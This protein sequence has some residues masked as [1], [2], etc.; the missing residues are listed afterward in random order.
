M[1]KLHAVIFSF[2]IFSAVFSNAYALRLKVAALSPE[3]ST[4][5]N[6][7]KQGAKEISQ[8]TNGRVKF[9]FYPG[10]VMGSDKTVLRK[11]QVG[12]LH[13]A[14]FSNGMLNNLYNGS[15]VYNL[16]LKFNSY[17]EIDYVRPKIDPLIVQGLKKNGFTTLVLSE[18]GFAYLMSTNPISTVEELQQQKAWVPEN[19]NTASEAM[20]AFSVTPIPLPLQDVLIALQTGMVNVVA[21]SPIG[22]ITLQWHTKIRYATD[23]PIAYVYGGFILSNKAMKKIS[24]EDQMIVKEVMQRVSVE[25]NKVTRKDNIAATEAIKNQGVKW[26]KPADNIISQLKSM[27]VSANQNLVNST[28]MD[29]SI[30]KQLDTHLNKFRQKNSSSK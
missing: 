1:I 13:G 12:Q 19:N 20:K 27:I 3:G 24:K 18:M 14:V 25:M 28:D 23:L 17:D 8:K 4:W 7:L 26:I 5:I 16:V 10:G 9:K 6:L 29:Q 2:L 11:M 15:Q 21:G 22:A 30:V